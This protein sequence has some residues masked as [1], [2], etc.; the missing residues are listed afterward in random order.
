VLVVTQRG[1]DAYARL[2]V[3]LLEALES[4]RL[5]RVALETLP[6]GA[7]GLSGAARADELVGRALARRGV[8]RGDAMGRAEGPR[9][10]VTCIVVGS[11]EGPHLVHFHTGSFAAL[12]A[13]GPAL[14]GVALADLPTALL[15]FDLCLACAER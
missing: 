15:S 7:V 5:A 13:V 9:G 8:V 1:G 6:G 3:R 2:T 12:P 14:A 10:E 11:A 4:L